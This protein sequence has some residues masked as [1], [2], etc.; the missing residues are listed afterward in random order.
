MMNSDILDDIYIRGAGH[1]VPQQLP[2]QVPGEPRHGPALHLLAA[3]RGG[4]RECSSQKR[5]API[6]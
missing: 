2:G 4:A 5:C 3:E 1:L 6:Y